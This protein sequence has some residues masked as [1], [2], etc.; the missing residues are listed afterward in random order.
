MRSSPPATSWA[1]APPLSGVFGAGMAT[2]LRPASRVRKIDVQGR[3][4]QAASASTNPSVGESNVTEIGLI[5]AGTGP[6]VGPGATVEPGAVVPGDVTDVE[7]WP[8]GGDGGRD[9]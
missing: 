2:Q 4:E 8:G 1:D 6:P 7:D 3:G 9:G 5:P